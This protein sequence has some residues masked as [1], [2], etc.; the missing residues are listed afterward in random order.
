MARE[1]KKKIDYFLLLTVFIISVFGLAILTSASFPASQEKFGESF[2]Y[3]KRQIFFGILPG[4]FIGFLCFKLPLKFFKKRAPIFLLINIAI[5]ALV[6]IPGLGIKIGGAV[7]WLNLKFISFQPSEFLKITFILYLG[8]WLSA[9]KEKKSKE[10]SKTLFAFLIILGLI[11]IFLI[12][13]PDVSTL[14]I[15]I[16]TALVMYFLAETPA[17][18][19]ILV[20]LI[21]GGLILFLIMSAEYRLNRILIFL[22]P[23]LDPLGRGYQLKQSLIGVGAG[24]VFGRGFG[25][26]QQKFGFLPATISDSIFSVLAEETG[27]IGSI[28]LTF[29][30]LIFFLRGFKIGRET[31]DAFSRIVALGITWW[32]TFQAFFNIGAMIG[33]FPLTGIPLPFISSGGSAIIAELTAIGILLN[34]SKN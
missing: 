2:Y 18:H 16:I 11:S 29:F 3:L 30:Y 23:N 14:I 22:N 32:L 17:W 10:L 31:Q 20:C 12:L 13:Q 27:F 8:S 24:R 28:I 15:L 26:S 6:F 25:F 33:I 21:L 5:L 34:I 1:G 19:T 4:F 7:R 9:R